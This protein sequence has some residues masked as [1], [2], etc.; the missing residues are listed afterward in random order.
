MAMPVGVVPSMVQTLSMS[1]ESACVI[2][3]PRRLW[4]GIVQVE[5]LAHGWRYENAA[6]HPSLGAGAMDCAKDA[7]R[8]HRRIHRKPVH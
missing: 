6:C 8:A 1:T 4:S 2:V 3:G 7:L 5:C